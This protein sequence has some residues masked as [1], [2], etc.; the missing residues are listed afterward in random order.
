MT[1][2]ENMYIYIFYFFFINSILKDY[3]LLFSFGHEKISLA[4]LMI[5]TVL[6]H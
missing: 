1:I 6:Y 4:N 3:N 2:L 5:V